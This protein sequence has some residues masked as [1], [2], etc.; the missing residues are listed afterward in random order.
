MKIAYLINYAGAGGTEKYVRIMSEAAQKDGHE[1]IFIYNEHGA[2]A[3]FMAGKGIK[4]YRLEMR[5]PFDFKAAKRLAEICSDERVDLV[6]VQFPRENYIAILSKLYYNIKVIFTCHLLYEPHP[7]WRMTNFVMTRFDKNV[8]AVCSAVKNLLIKNGVGRNKVS[9]IYNGIVPH[10]ER[11]SQTDIRK[12]H[13][14][15]PEDFLCVILGR[16]TAEKGLDFLVRSFAKLKG[17][18]KCII[19]GEGPLY[20]DI[21]ALIKEKELE[22]TVIQAGYRTNVFDYLL[23]ADASLNSSNSEAFS[24]AILEGMAAALPTVATDVG[25]NGEMLRGFELCGEIVPYGDENAF[26]DAV[27]VLMSDPALCDTYS[28]NALFN[29]SNHFHLDIMIEKTLKLYKEN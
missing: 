7:L 20:D 14:I 3:D 6:H 18:A 2:L 21:K 4:S 1:V 22:N 27:E 9:V 11:K 26:A 25:G 12:E 29:L 24:F 16:Y 23:S 8:I 13:G 15:S 17:K 19:L 5:R 28:K 10:S